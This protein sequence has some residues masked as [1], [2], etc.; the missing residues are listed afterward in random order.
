MLIYIGETGVWFDE[1][2]NQHKFAVKGCDISNSFAAH[3]VE[4]GHS[5]KWDHFTFIEEHK[6]QKKKNQRIS[7]YVQKERCLGG[8]KYFNY[9]WH[10][11]MVLLLPVLF[12][13]IWFKV[14]FSWHNTYSTRCVFCT[15]KINNIQA[16]TRR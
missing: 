14:W 8:N 10:V 13:Q 4:T 15:T 5:I 16:V 3:I 12:M 1:R 7:V 9:W 11:W 2:E 6:Y